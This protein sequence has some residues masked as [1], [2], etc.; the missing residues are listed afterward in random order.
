MRILAGLKQ[1]TYIADFELPEPELTESIVQA[2]A[3]LKPL[4]ACKNGSTAPEFTVFGQSHLDLAWLWPVE[5]TIRK[6]AR[7]YSN[8]LAL[9]AEY[10][11]Y[12]F[13]LCEPPILWFAKP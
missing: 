1:F 3:V 4:L 8:Q 10:G 7:T 2:D 6:A 9:M 5:E 12:H 13:L 11:D